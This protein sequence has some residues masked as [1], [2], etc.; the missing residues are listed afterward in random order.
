M[1]DPKAREG[2]AGGEVSCKLQ[3]GPSGALPEASWASKLC[4]QDLMP[5][6]WNALFP[7]LLTSNARSPH[8]ILKAQVMAPYVLEQWLKGESWSQKALGLEWS[9]HLL[10][11]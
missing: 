9:P 2:R 10:A 7:S 3:P 8:P 1:P 5:L 6:A 4:S 11:V